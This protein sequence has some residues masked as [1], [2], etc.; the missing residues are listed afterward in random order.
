MES[1][2]ICYAVYFQ[3][4]TKKE[5]RSETKFRT[6]EFFFLL[7]SIQQVML[8]LAKNPSFF[9][10]RLGSTDFYVNGRSS[11]FQKETRLKLL[12]RK[13]DRTQ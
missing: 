11:G 5:R 4:F 2:R 9:R 6:V 3:E 10:N 7:Q 8:D 1:G 13:T 12:V